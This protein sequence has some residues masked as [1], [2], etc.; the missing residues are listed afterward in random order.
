[1]K[2]LEKFFNPRNTAARKI[3]RIRRKEYKQGLDLYQQER[4]GIHYLKWLGGLQGTFRYAQGLPSNLV[5][6]IGAGST[7][8]IKSI[9]EQK[10]AKKFKF[11]ATVLSINTVNVSQPDV[12]N[13]YSTNLKEKIDENLGL[14][15]VHITSAE[16]LRPFAN[17]STAIVLSLYSLPYCGSPELAVQNI[18]RILVPGGIF[19]GVF[20]IDMLYALYGEKRLQKF[21]PLF[22]EYQYDIA[23]HVKNFFQSK[24]GILLAIKKDKERQISAQNVL[25]EDLNTLDA[26]LKNFN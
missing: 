6:D 17:N 14:E 4:S 26:S 5:V 24:I 1:M 9:S 25:N 16:A 18:D 19:K 21:T 7:R 12:D 11:K 3:K 23:V 15:N 8:G 2:S 22:E 10:F 13:L 20:P